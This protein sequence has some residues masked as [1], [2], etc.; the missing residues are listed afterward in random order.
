MIT[1]NDIDLSSFDDKLSRYLKGQ[2]SENEEKEYRKLLKEDPELRDKAVAIARLA[3]AMDEVGSDADREIIS[4]LG[5]VTP[6]EALRIA[7]E[8]SISDEEHPA[9]AAI[10]C[11]KSPVM[12]LILSILIAASILICVFGG[13]KYYKYQQVSSLA[14]EYVSYFPASEFSRGVS[15][16]FAD[17]LDKYRKNI[18]SKKDLNGTISELQIIW[19]E[20]RKD[21]YNDYTEYM[22]QIGWLLANAYI[23]SGKKSE[24]VAVL[25]QLIAD[26]PKDSAMAIKSN[27]LKSKIEKH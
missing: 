5:E 22:P 19:E 14:T 4:S 27:E 13:Y 10:A 18:E 3:K 2:M 1:P 20:S 26:S 12:K 25:N 16:P 7:A 17:T 24:A 23:R 11:K 6:V 21:I 9:S 15:D 8:G